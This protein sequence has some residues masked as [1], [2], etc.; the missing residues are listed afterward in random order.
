VIRLGDTGESVGR[1]FRATATCFGKVIKNI[2]LFLKF[3]LVDWPEA[4]L[5]AV[6]FLSGD[7]WLLFLLRAQMLRQ[8]PKML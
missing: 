8:L 7:H 1:L 4:I 3:S 2:T 6:E 5:T